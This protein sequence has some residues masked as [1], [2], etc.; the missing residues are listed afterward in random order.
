MQTI[1]VLIIFQLLKNEFVT[2]N[3]PEINVHP[4][5]RN[6][7]SNPIPKIS[8]LQKPLTYANQFVNNNYKQ[9]ESS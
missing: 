8:I 5:Y 7:I 1:K 9:Q 3:N 6:N 2:K 4:Q